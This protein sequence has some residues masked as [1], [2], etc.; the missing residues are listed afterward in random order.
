MKVTIENTI[1][2]ALGLGLT[3]LLLT[4][5]AALW[6]ARRSVR[7]SAEV[8]QAEHTLDLLR[9]M[10]A[11]T[12]DVETASRGFVITGQKQFLEPYSIGRRRI[13]ELLDELGHATSGDVA[14]R[15]NLDALRPLIADEMASATNLIFLKNAAGFDA[16]KTFS[17]AQSGKA[18]MDSIRRLIAKMES[19][20]QLRLRQRSDDAHATYLITTAVIAL[21]G[22]LALLVV[23]IASYVA[24]RDFS[25]RRKAELE[26]D[27]FF[28][29]T[30][31]LVCF[32]SFDGYFKTLNP[33]WERLLGYSRAEL[34]SKPF[35]EFVHPE[36]RA[37]TIAEAE[38][39]AM[40]G[41]SIQFENRYI[42]KNGTY[43]WLS[44]NARS[45]VGQKLIYATA[46]D[47]TAQKQ[48]AEQIARLNADL[49]QRARELQESEER[50]RLMIGSITDYAVLLL[51]TSGRVVSWN[52]GAER[53]KGY[54]AE[55]IVGH[56][57]SRFY[58]EEDSNAGKPAQALKTAV[59]SGRFEDI[60]WRVRKDGSRFWA[61]VVV[62]PV[63]DSAGELQGF[64]KVT[65]DITERKRAEEKLLA[66]H[67][68]LQR[69]AMQLEAANKELEAFSYS[70]SHDLRAPL[71]HIDGFVSR[72]EQTAG[73]SL[74]EK[75]R[76]YLGIIS[77]SAKQ[78]GRLIDDL[79]VFS[80]M[81]RAE[82]RNSLVDLEQLAREAMNDFQEET[83]QRNI[84]WK[85]GNLPEVRGDPAMLRQVLANLVGNAVKYTRP[86][87]HPEIEIGSSDSA[88]EFVIFVR[89]NGVGFEMEYAHK[90]F[91]VFQR[92]H[93]A[94]E[95]EG[96]GIG[97]AN[98]R[99]IIHR[100]GGRTWA[101]GKV[102]GGATFYFSLPKYQKGTI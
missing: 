14:E 32:A 87:E 75:S 97:L 35:I 46:R 101:E 44:W 11:S 61:D 28:E 47:I 82:M 51:D 85:N 84:V 26:R 12:L 62:R 59:E 38:K 15:A 42:A 56:H 78:M 81:G 55:E 9:G 22:F 17:V 1:R 6:S 102:N 67:E 77:D 89:D 19:V 39:L 66:L 48:A 83:R 8:E 69:R 93:R 49:R 5:G 24:H 7:I 73:E 99:R 33:A 79:L 30:R 29:V 72:L 53:I 20:E 98:V 16:A 80:R 21:G 31:D 64:V 68:E 43:H 65:R 45:S 90:L 10:L 86:R 58:P 34:A 37:A 13:A 91:G 3:F 94:E 40:G 92:L 18:T 25:R 50:V 96:T 95:F 71:R 63:R 23:G 41:D 100:H 88:D 54:R 4:S 52:T 2:G 57:F 60:G 76:R 27:G 74:G 70:V 36:D